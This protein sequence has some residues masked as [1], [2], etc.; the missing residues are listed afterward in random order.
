MD[1][2]RAS[3]SSL[4][5]TQFA[6]GITGEVQFKQ[7]FL[8]ELAEH[9][10]GLEGYLAKHP[11][12]VVRGPQNSLYIIDHHHLALTLARE[13]YDKVPIKVAHDFSNGTMA[14]FWQQMQDARLLYLY[15]EHGHER[16][17]AELPK[18]LADMKDDP[19]RSLA[20]FVRH[21]GGY[22]KA[23]ALYVEFQWAGYFR[24]RIDLKIVTESFDAAITMAHEL[25]LDPAAKNLPGYIGAASSKP[26]AASGRQ[27]TPPA[28]PAPRT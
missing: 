22:E 14:E 21:R 5:A 20:W 12:L 7:K 10:L 19:Y 28:Q 4:K 2:D 8:R 18:T 23:D 17:I 15:D 24:E 16:S 25:A 13:K 27:T 1:L 11:I 3:L 6:A 9:P 26:P